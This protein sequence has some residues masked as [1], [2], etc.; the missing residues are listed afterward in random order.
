MFRFFIAKILPGI[1]FL[2]FLL[3]LILSG[4]I[5]G[6]ETQKPPIPPPAKKLKI[7]SKTDEQI[8][9]G[10]LLEALSSE[11]RWVDSVFSTLTPEERIAQLMVV[12]G[13]SNQG[14]RYEKDLL[15]LVK[16]YKVGGIIFFQ[17]GPIRQARLT[18]KLQEASKVPLMLS[19]DAES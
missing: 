6:C 14:R 18:N 11:S 10:T 7:Y 8:R 16:K 19:M 1:L 5:P 3:F 13:Y 9:Q 12:E 15:M 17:G 4:V 2:A